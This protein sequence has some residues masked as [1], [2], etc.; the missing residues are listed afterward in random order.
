MWDCCDL[1]RARVR[2][3]RLAGRSLLHVQHRLRRKWCMPTP[4]WKHTQM[5]VHLPTTLQA[6]PGHTC[7]ILPPSE[8]DLGLCLAVFEG[9]GG[10]Y[11][12]HRIG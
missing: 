4:A 12:F 9:S 11:L 3:A 1:M 2:R 6:L 8:I 7:H 10:R 5:R